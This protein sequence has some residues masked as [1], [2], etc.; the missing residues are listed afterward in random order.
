MFVK[1]VFKLT[2]AHTSGRI[3]SI[4][5]I[6][7]QISAGICPAPGTSVDKDTISAETRLSFPDI[8]SEKESI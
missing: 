7:P 4:Y 8:S 5:Q 3:S 1:L 2:P 6:L